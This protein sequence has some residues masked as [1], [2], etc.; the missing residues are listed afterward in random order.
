MAKV[1]IRCRNGPTPEL[2]GGAAVP[3]VMGV[4]GPSGSAPGITTGGSHGALCRDRRVAGAEQRVR[5]RQHRADRARGQGG[6]RAGGARPSLRSARSAADPR[7]PRGRALVAV[8]PRGP[9]Q[10][11][12]R[13]GAAGDP[14]RQGGALG[15]GGQDRPQGRARHRPAAAH[16]LVPAGA[17]QVA[18]GA[19]GPG[20]PGRAQAPARQTPGRRAQHPGHPARLRAQARPETRSAG[21]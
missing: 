5:G 15:H 16:G 1:E 18:A 12:V 4:R 13:G 20:A 14:A 8:A 9:Y 3:R 19:G 10:G 11:R 21:G 6:E 7:R 2:T 17:P